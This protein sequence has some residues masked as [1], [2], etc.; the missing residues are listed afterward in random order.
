MM[1]NEH[2][3]THLDAP[4]HFDEAGTSIDQLPLPELIGRARLLDMRHKKALEPIGPQDLE[5]ALEG[6]PFGEGEAAVVWTG[7]SANYDRDDYGEV[8]PFISAE[9]ADWL[10]SKRPSL[11]VTDLVGLDE[12]ADLTQ[13]VH[14]K[15]LLAGLYML[16]VTT[17][18]ERLSQ[19]QWDICAFPIKLVGG[20]GAAVRAFAAR[21][22]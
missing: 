9:G 16:Q 18:I 3:G 5:H 8:R 12:P 11:L 22:G 4:C 2:A 1:L 20:T 19:G 13:P 17:G 21:V 14:N 15:V 10:V 7:H 6:R